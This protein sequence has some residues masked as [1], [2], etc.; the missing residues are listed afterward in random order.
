MLIDFDQVI[1]DIKNKKYKIL[2]SGSGRTVFDLQNGYVV[3]VAKNKRGLA[4]NE[5]EY[6]IFSDINNHLMK[7]HSMKHYS[8]LFAGIPAASSDFR[9]IVMEKAE[10]VDHISSVFHYFH[11]GSK[12]EF[13][14]LKEFKDISE[15]YDLLLSDLCRH[16]NWGLIN[17]R[18]VVVDYGYT[19]EVMRKY[20]ALF[21]KRS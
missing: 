14:N 13:Q 3:K 1:Y 4:Q 5:V 6:K 8:N 11:V 21:K 7:T 15:R 17:G 20:Y 19:R 18:P 2:G 12:S 10:K 9:L 16:S